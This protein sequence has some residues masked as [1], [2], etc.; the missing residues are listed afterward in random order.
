MIWLAVDEDGAE[1]I[2][3]SLPIRIELVG[4]QRFWANNDGD[5]DD[6]FIQLP[7]GTIEKISG[8]QLTWENE[9]LMI[10]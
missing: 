8:I 9:P 3:D 10:E 7:K 6:S 2:Y 4:R 5:S 1:W